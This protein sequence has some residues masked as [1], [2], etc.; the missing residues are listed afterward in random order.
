MEITF[1]KPGKYV[2]AVSGGVDSV[3]LLDILHKKHTYELV[4]AHF[5]HGIRADSPTDRHLVQAMAAAYGLPFFYEEGKLGPQVSEA[6]AREARYKFL[7][8]IANE[9]SARAMI[10]AHHQ[11]DLLETA[12]LNMLRG[13]ARKGLSSLSSSSEIIRPLLKVSKQD[14]MKYARD[15]SLN[16]REDSTNQDANYLRNYVRLNILPKFNE[17]DKQKLLKTLNS[18]ATTNEELDSILNDML[19][20]AITQ[21]GVSRQWFNQLPHGIAK[22][23]MAAWLRKEQ[24]RDFNSGT[25]ER[26]VVGAKT[27]AAGKSIDAV[28]GVRLIVGKRYLAL[29]GLER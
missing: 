14:L 8:K 18:A 19:A 24:I 1:P 10:T 12:I 2:V 25:I 13:T 17:I 28:K 16:W 23:F 7:K 15:N 26:L 5:D 11:D 22:E 6:A 3:A 29:K 21:Q 4:V 9:N 27:A 20:E